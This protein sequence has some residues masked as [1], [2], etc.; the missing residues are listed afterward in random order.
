MN[1]R[2][3]TVCFTGHRKIIHSDVRQHLEEV[4]EILI[5]DGF[6][7]FGSGGALGFD[8]LAAQTVIRL[9]KKY[10]RIKLILV[11]P[12]AA[13][14]KGWPEKDRKIYYD[15]MKN[16]DKLTFISKEYKRGCFHARNRYLVDNS[17]VCVAYQYKG[18]GGTAYTVDYAE[19]HGCNVIFL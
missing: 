4:I 17:S 7:Y 19:K 16:A 11:I 6:T 2:D 5:E 18:C 3:K 9:K 10:S 14:A 12:F 1:Q 15:I 8:T 13:Q